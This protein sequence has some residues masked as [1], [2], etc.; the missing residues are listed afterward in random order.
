LT[1]EGKRWDGYRGHSRQ[2]R[3]G[4]YANGGWQASD[5]VN[6]RAFATY[7]DNDQRLPGALTRSEM[8][9]DPRRA[10]ADAIGGD[11]GKVVKTA[12]GALRTTWALGADRSLVAG[13]SYEAQS[14]YHPIVDRIFV[15]FD[16]PGPNP[17]VEVFSLLIDTDH[18]DLGGVVRYSQRAGAHQVLAGLNYG[19]GSVDGGNYRNA[20]GRPNGVSEYVDN[21][22]DSL[23]AF[24]ADH[25]QAAGRFTVVLG[26]QYVNAGR[27][28]RTINAQTG[29]LSHPEDR[30][31]SL[32]PRLGVIASLNG[33]AEL[34]G[35]VSRLFE[36]P[37]TFE[38][39]DDVRGGNATLDP[40]KG[41]VAEIGWRSQPRSSAG[42]RWTWDASAYYARID[43]EILSVD[44]PNAPGKSLTTNI[45]RTVHAGV[46][47]LV[48]ASLAVGD[49]HRIE[50]RV[51]VSLNR[52]H[53]DGD[54]VY[55]DNDLPGTP[56]YAVRGEVLYRHACG[57]YAGPTFDLVGG[58]HVDFANA[59]PVD[60]HALMGLRAGFTGKRWE[61]FGE[62]RN[63]FD[64]KYVA[65]LN[66]LDVAGA[67]ARVLYP[68]GPRS[69]QVGARVSF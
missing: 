25:W 50:P 24:V 15:D 43:D 58:R 5:A 47:A 61:V 14:L 33:A 56:S 23:E 35:N 11:Y 9:A 20:G 27:D 12:R 29:A 21:S 49:A 31:S 22:A 68:G 44:D 41:M 8:G 60:G 37:T 45:D 52:F 2:E 39:Q 18:R 32:N 48:S 19:R 38:M 55:G 4:V 6:I 13:L 54:A 36:A 46:E 57:L 62:L 65:A 1:V 67:D 28:V 16:G 66:V 3:W 34:Y 69:A 10:S 17:P 53:F 40:M 26:A 64:E 30:Y 63:L 59:Y 42:L 51:S 7:V